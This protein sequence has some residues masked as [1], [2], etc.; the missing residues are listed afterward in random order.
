MTDDHTNREIDLCNLREYGPATP[1]G[2]LLNAYRQ[3][4]FHTAST[5]CGPAIAE[6][7]QTV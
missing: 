2:V 7:K 5:H 1:I 6:F 3:S 4:R